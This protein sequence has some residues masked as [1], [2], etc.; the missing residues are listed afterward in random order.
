M[1]IKQ[2]KLNQEQQKIEIDLMVKNPGLDSSAA[3]ELAKVLQKQR[4]TPEDYIAINAK[5]QDFFQAKL[6]REL[7]SINQ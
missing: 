7:N 1:E 4:K 3:A 6:Q 2:L 5:S